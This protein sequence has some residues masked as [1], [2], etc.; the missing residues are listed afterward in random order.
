MK[1]ADILADKKEQLMETGN[2]L[3]VTFTVDDIN[4][5]ADVN[6]LRM[7]KISL[8]FPSEFEQSG[9]L[10]ECTRS[11]LDGDSDYRVLEF[12]ALKNKVLVGPI[13]QVFS[14]IM[15]R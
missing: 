15:K 9:D 14:K 7:L 1:I 8:P 12:C 2:P 10:F 5:L 11:I 3:A 13:K 6:Q 4:A